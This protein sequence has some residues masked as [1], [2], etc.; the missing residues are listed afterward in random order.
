MDPRI[1]IPIR[2]KNKI[3]GNNTKNQD[4][5]LYPLLQIKLRTHVQK[6]I[7]NSFPKNNNPIF[8]HSQE[9]LPTLYL[10]FPDKFCNSINTT[11]IIEITKYTNAGVHNFFKSIAF[12]IFILNTNKKK[13]YI[14]ETV[15]EF[16]L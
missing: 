3:K 14:F 4:T 12:V 5:F 10:P 9:Y 8:P 2:I 1:N 11:E 6:K 15:V 13:V 16:V 7:Y